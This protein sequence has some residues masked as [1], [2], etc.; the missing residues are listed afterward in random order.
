MLKPRLSVT[1]PLSPL[2][3]SLLPLPSLRSSLSL[4]LSHRWVRWTSPNLEWHQQADQLFEFTVAEKIKR[5]QNKQKEITVGTCR[6]KRGEILP[7]WK[8]VR[9]WTRRWQ[10]FRS[11]SVRLRRPSARTTKTRWRNCKTGALHTGSYKPNNPNLLSLCVWCL[12]CWKI[13]QLSILSSVSVG[14]QPFLGF[15]AQIHLA[16][17]TEKRLCLKPVW[18]VTWLVTR[19]SIALLLLHVSNGHLLFC[20]YKRGTLGSTLLIFEIIHHPIYYVSF[21]MF[22]TVRSSYPCHV[23]NSRGHWYVECIR[24]GEASLH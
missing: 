16:L 15:L 2:C 14:N 6:Q 5:T 21:I 11:S 20:S 3:P 4:F 23:I 24:E 8:S 22:H 18:R 17:K 7:R 19:R 1:Y 12:V 9:V 13:L 10:I